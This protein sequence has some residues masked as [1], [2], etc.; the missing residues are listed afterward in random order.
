MNINN[1]VPHVQVSPWTSINLYYMDKYHHEHQKLGTTGTSIAMDK[2]NFVTH[3]QVSPWTS[4]KLYHK[5]KYHH[6]NQ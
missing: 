6:E 1:F 4:M 2:N 3:V 5:D